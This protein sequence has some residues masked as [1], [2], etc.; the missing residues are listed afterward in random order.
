MTGLEWVG[1]GLALVLL[2]YLFVALLLPEK[3]S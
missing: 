2:G 3:L 1:A